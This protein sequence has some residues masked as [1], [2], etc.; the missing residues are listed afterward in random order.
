MEVEAPSDEAEYASGSKGKR[1]DAIRCIMFLKQQNGCSPNKLTNS[2]EATH[3]ATALN[4]FCCLLLR[5]DPL[6]RDLL[7]DPLRDLLRD[8]LRDP[9]RGHLRDP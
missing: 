3:R 4:S 6:R 1:R 9:L 2:E 7:R 5:R 8:P